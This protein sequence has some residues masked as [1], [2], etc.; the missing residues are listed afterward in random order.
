MVKLRLEI[1]CSAL[2]C[3]TAIERDTTACGRGSVGG[4]ALDSHDARGVPDELRDSLF[5]PLV[6]GR[7]DGTGLGLA[8]SREIAL[9]HGGDLRYTSRP[10]ETVFSLY[11]PMERP[12]D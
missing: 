9:E 11:L 5:Q 6:S 10:G 12:H 3:D 4:Q 7:P 8:L 2:R 1:N